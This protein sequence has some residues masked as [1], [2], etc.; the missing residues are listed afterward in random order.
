MDLGQPRGKGSQFFVRQRVRQIFKC[1]R[2]VASLYLEFAHLVDANGGYV[3][4]NSPVSSW[5]RISAWSRFFLKTTFCWRRTP[6]TG[7]C[8]PRHTLRPYRA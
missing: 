6:A 8:N 3:P 4:L 2:H 7:A 5:Q 1:F